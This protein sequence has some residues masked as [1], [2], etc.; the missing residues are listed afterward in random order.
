M[1]NENSK[2]KKLFPL[3][4]LQAPPENKG[5]GLSETEIIQKKAEITMLLK[6]YGII[7]N[8][9]VVKEGPS[10]C[11]FRITNPYTT[12]VSAIEKLISNPPKSFIIDFVRV[13]ANLRNGIINIEFPNEHLERVS[14]RGALESEDYLNSDYE[15]P[16]VIGK[17][18]DGYFAF[19]L[20][21][22]PHILMGGAIA[23][24]KTTCLNAIIT[25]LLYS[26]LPSELK[27]VLIDPKKVE[28][29]AYNL[30]SDM[31]FQKLP[32]VEPFVQTET[33][34]IVNALNA[35]CDEMDARFTQLKELDCKN[36]TEYN[37][38]I[39]SGVLSIDDKNGI[40]PYI[41]VIIDEFADLIFTAGAEFERPVVL[42]AQLARDVGIHLVIS[43]QRPS[44]SVITGFIKAN[45]PAR[46]A[47]RVISAIDSRTILDFDGAND[48]I[49]L[50]E[51]LFSD[52]NELF[53]IQGVNIKEAEVKAV[54]E[55]FYDQ[56][57]LI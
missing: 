25:S 53:C 28:F 37:E 4:L 1:E 47:F 33:Y 30:I 40:L 15:L 16:C 45:F 2:I 50:G 12:R 11:L 14:M 43:T 10:S 52:G 44:P 22:M 34:E 26:K 32:G 39:K 20:T 18:Y 3:K 27:F 7:V 46:I 17:S 51:M 48:I 13:T 35:L 56:S 31:Y 49:N 19:D 24:G 29:G 6:E 54:V 36:I 5:K 8:D 23:Q 57:N 9:I 55:Y 38:K 21:Q 41:V 42:L